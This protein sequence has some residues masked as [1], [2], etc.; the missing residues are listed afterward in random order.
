MKTNRLLTEK[1]GSGVKLKLKTKMKISKLWLGILLGAQ[2]TFT[3]LAADNT[4]TNRDA[5]IEALKQ[6]INALSQKVEALENRRAT[7]QQAATNIAN[8]QI[9]ELDQKVRIL[10]RER[11]LDQDAAAAA[12]KTQPK[13]TVGPSGFTA[14]SADSNFVFS[15]KGLVQVDSRTFFDDTAIKSN[16]GFLLRRARPIFQGTLYRDFDFVFIPDFGGSTVQ[17]FDAYANYRYAPWAQLRAG[18]FKTPEGLEQLQADVNT[19]FNE[20]SLVTDLVPNRDVGLQLW[21]DIN[22]GVLSYAAGILNG[23][24]DARNSSNVAFENEIELAGRLF[25]QPFKNSDITALQGLGFGVAG[26]SEHD[27]ATATGLPSTTGGTLPGYTTDGQQQFFAYN[28]ATGLVLANG[29]HWRLSPQ[30]YYYFGPLSLL[31]EYAISDQQVSKGAAKADL[32]NTAWEISG[33]WVLTGENAS[34]T[35]V[36]PLH[37]FDP[38]NGQWGALQVVARYEE[39]NIDDN[40]FPVFANPATSASGAQ[41]WSAGLN[42]F[43]NKNIR[44]NAS[45]SH[46]TFTGGGGAGTTAPAIVTRQPENVFF[47]RLQLAF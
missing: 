9:Q 2:L 42:W 26:T 32:Q 29:E 35:G 31:G 11:E 30:G 15:L 38:H 7:E 13:L 10:A 44:V 8:A 4:D 22:G 33:G 39:L 28:P 41:A 43:L 45:F 37:P 24:G 18:K 6:Q 40:A 3:S 27:S 47:T 21:G 34:F 5:D 20:R 36:T 16:D 1:T 19:S 14:S 25:A 12:A 23:V 17:I 46:T